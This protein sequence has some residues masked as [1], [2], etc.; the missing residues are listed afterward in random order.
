MRLR[1][2]MDRPGRPMERTWRQICGTCLTASSEGGT[3]RVLSSGCTSRSR[4]AASGPSASRCVLH[5]AP[6]A[7][8][9]GDNDGLSVPQEPADAPPPSVYVWFTFLA[10]AVYCVAGGGCATPQGSPG[11]G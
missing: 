4:M 1:A 9:V 7:N 10:S 2:L 6:L 11:S 5:T 3:T 8:G